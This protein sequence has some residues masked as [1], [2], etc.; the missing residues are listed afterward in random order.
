MYQ[1]RVW[2][3]ELFH[4]ESVWQNCLWNRRQ[5]KINTEIAISVITAETFKTYLSK[6]DQE[7]RSLDLQ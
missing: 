6:R 4:E 2:G 1:S 5:L 7:D 3:G